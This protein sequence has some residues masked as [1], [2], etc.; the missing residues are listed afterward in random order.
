MMEQY[1]TVLVVM[2]IVACSSYYV[3]F[4][5]F[6]DQQGDSSLIRMAG[7]QSKLI[8][9]T[10]F[11]ASQLFLTQEKNEVQKLKKNIGN[12][13]V[14]IGDNNERLSHGQKYVIEYGRPTY[15][16]NALTPD[17]YNIFFSKPFRLD[18]NT[19]NYIKTIKSFVALPADELNP[20]NPVVKEFAELDLKPLSEGLDK[21]STMLQQQSEAKIN[22]A[23]DLQNIM[24][25]VMILSLIVLGQ[26]L[27]R[28]LVSKLK[29]SMKK[30][31][32]EQ[33]FTDT[34]INTAQAL[35]IA[36]DKEGNII[37]F[38]HFAE[39]TTGW[40]SEEAL[41]LNF[42]EK[43]I[44]HS[45][46]E[47]T[48]TMFDTMMKSKDQLSQELET[49]LVIRSG[50]LLDIMWHNMVIMDSSTKEPTL[51][52]ATGIDITERKLSDQKLQEAHASLEHL[53]ER[54]QSEVNLAA[55]LQKV[56]MANP[57]IDL[58]GLHGQAKMATSSEVGG[59]YYD[60]YDIDGTESVVLVGDV[61]GHGV[62]AGTM[63]S[64]A[65][66]GVSSLIH[67]GITNPSAIL[68]GLNETMFETAQQELLMTMACIQLD[69]KTGQMKFANAG[70]VLPYLRH[71]ES[72]QWEMIEAAGIPLGQNLEADYQATEAE[73]QM[74]VGDRLFLFT[75][76]LVEEES[77]LGE[78]FGYERLEMILDTYGDAEPEVIFEQL[79]VALKAH[80]G[81]DGFEDDITFVIMNHTDR[82]TVS[83]TTTNDAEPSDIIR[84]T[85]AVYRQ[86]SHAIPRISRQ[87]L[88]MFPE[89]DF[90]DLLPR[91]RQDGICRVLPK[92]DQL[93]H[94]LG[95]SRF[96][97]Q[98][99][100][101]VDDDLYALLPN[102]S[103]KRQFQL[104]HTED[105]A[106][107]MEEVFA[108]LSEQ[109]GIREDYIESLNVLLDEMLEN[110]LYAAPRDGRDTAYYQ[111]GEVRELDKIEEVRVDVAFNGN[112]LGLM[113][114]DNWGTLTPAVFMRS[115]SQAMQNGVK[116]GT[117]GGGLYMM[118]RL[119]DYLQV[120]VH[121]HKRTQITILWDMSEEFE[122]NLNTGFQFLNHAEEQEEVLN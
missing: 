109:D 35:I 49:Q 51:F 48:Q 16:E 104:T 62:A 1:G 42:F 28:P 80:T 40:F 67:K 12:N 43:F 41:G 95:W 89:G 2:G 71:K 24:F 50:E 31:Q 13:L 86:G 75:D 25:I 59:D 119:S 36:V 78:A 68:Q 32:S 52:L 5:N 110:G 27:L 101:G 115:L 81:R 122:L 3:V 46:R 54:L 93:C 106:F 69:A 21:F 4:S 118:W 83:A 18:T 37:N 10:N 33:E 57:M 11:L 53:S 90:A 117:G 63:V 65:K 47:Q 22:R 108:W 91:F 14:R 55:T 82:V 15:I 44:A 61:S 64:A 72:R 76:G 85:D 45:D 121:P 116:A 6:K 60:Y 99:H 97:N 113:V 112:T 92:N 19:R 114:T 20:Q 34:L 9:R 79:N 74:E 73:I 66:A 103:N 56:M 120:R 88:A 38:N 96:M 17:Q 23:I 77:P 105:K 29:E 30:A 94:R 84:I 87:Y 70:H 111:K 39:E 8:Q 58:P 7:E 100:Q 26:A 98:H 107:I 102:E